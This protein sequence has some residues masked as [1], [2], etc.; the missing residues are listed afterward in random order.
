M[1][2]G[3]GG[4][5][6][7]RRPR[8]ARPDRAGEDGDSPEPHWRPCLPA[9]EAHRGSPS[10]AVALLVVTDSLSRR[11]RHGDALCAPLGEHHARNAAAALA[12]RPTVRSGDRRLPRGPRPRPTSSASCPAPIPPSPARRWCSAPTTTT[13]GA[14][15]DRI[16]P[17]AD[18]NA[19]GTALVLELAR[20]L[21]AG[22]RAPAHRGPR[23]VLAARSSGSSLEPLR[24]HPGDAGPRTAAMLN[25]DMVA[26]SPRA[27]ARWAASRAA[28]VWRASGRAAAAGHRA[29]T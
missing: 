4:P 5:R 25:L 24:G 1:R 11:R 9:R 21:A 13:S 28:R 26:A 15:G 14:R 12:R 18:D 20:A 2:V 29:S 23:A 3:H 8:R 22:R 16:Y 27:V 19:S 10:G 17:G 7:L 6:R